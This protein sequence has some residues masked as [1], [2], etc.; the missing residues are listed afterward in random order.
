MEEKLEMQ[1]G[2]TQNVNS[3]LLDRI[4]TLRDQ[5][6]KGLA[7]DPHRVA[8]EIETIISLTEQFLENHRRRVN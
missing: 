4:S 1:Y 5:I 7:N 8:Q 3:E 6:S 2:Y